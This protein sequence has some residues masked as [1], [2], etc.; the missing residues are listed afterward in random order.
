MCFGTSSGRLSQLCHFGP[1]IAI[2]LIVYITSTGFICLIQ[3]WPPDTTAG[4]IHL[5]IYLM[6][7]LIIFYN[8]FNAVFVGPGFVP[9]NW[10]PVIIT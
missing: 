2:F 7:P 6:W 1:L 10:R 9:K 4:Q 8:Y 3:W 5:A